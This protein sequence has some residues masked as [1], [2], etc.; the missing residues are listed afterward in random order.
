MTSQILYIN[1]IDECVNN[2]LDSFY[3][4]FIKKK[5][6]SLDYISKN[7][8]K[9]KEELNK[10]IN[11]NIKSYNINT[12]ISN[13]IEFDKI[14]IIFNDY[15]L[16]YYFFFLAS[17]TELNKILDTLNILNKTTNDNFFKNRYITKY[18]S[19]YKYI[20]DYKHVLENYKKI[21]AKDKI[22]LTKYSDIVESLNT[23]NEQMITIILDNNQD[24]VHNILKIIILR[25]I[26]M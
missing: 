26:Y 5:K 18:S 22:F 3:L 11:I 24:L 13:K 16:L 10:L 23:M 7:F 2:I 17:N 9:F 1:T 19:Y 8:I 20:L 15:L 14:K 21:E 25:E 12:I 4:E 6:E